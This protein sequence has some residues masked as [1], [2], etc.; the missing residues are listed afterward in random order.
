M[1]QIRLENVTFG[2]T[3][4]LFKDVTLTI[5]DN[6]RI[7]LVGN[8]GTG[9][10]TLLKCIA[11]QIEPHTG[12]VVRPKGVRFGFIEQ[13]IPEGL[14][15]MNLFDVISAAI[16]PD[17]RDYNSWKVDIALDTFKAPDDIRHR[18]VREL[19]GGWQRLAL[20]ARIGLSEPDVLLLDEPTNHLDVA[21]ILVLEQ[22]LT[23][24]VYNIPLVTISHDRSFLTNCTNKTLFMRGVQVSEYDY[25][26]MRAKELLIEDDKVAASQRSKEL[27]EMERLKRSSH[28]LRQVGVNHHSDS[29]L[30]KSVQIAKRAATIGKDLTEVHVETRRD[31]KLNS[32]GTHAKR[33]VDFKDVTIC[34]PTGRTLFHIKKLEIAAGDRLVILGP[35]GSGKSQFLQHVQRAFSDI[36]AARNEGI[37]I[38]PT[39]KLGYLDQH[40]SQ[41]PLEK[42]MSDYISWE[43]GLD[44]HKTTSVLANAGFPMLT[45]NT[46][47]GSLSHGQRAR[48]ALLG[49][50]LASPNFYIMDEPTNHLDIAGQEQLESEIL[51]QGAASILV[52]HDREFAHNIGTKFYAINNGGLIEISSPEVFYRAVLDAPD[53]ESAGRNLNIKKKS[54]TPKPS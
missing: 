49:L 23:E 25:S 5:S 37:A 33:L 11:G 30:K 12:K 45:Q 8:N 4:T 10:S 50:R 46:K 2:Y 24:Q 34:D 6:D 19:S 9:K 41:L 36:E 15:D 48:I 32:S 20:I 29:A 21:K 28:E 53:V 52:S 22:W 16:P 7:G 13:D 17:E 38:T 18:P 1:T 40:L 42:S 44:N 43:Y 14:K 39:A 35:N 26:Y 3:D 54:L 51:E 31:I 27:K 47:L